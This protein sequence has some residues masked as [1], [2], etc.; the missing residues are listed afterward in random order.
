[1]T[2]EFTPYPWKVLE[3][4]GSDDVYGVYADAEN[5]FV[6]LTVSGPNKEAN[7]R[8]ISA[9]PELYEALENVLKAMETDED[10]EPQQSWLD[11]L[12]RSA[13]VARAALAKARGEQ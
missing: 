9:A 2:T 13:D 1:M 5:A 10:A 3:I 6:A 7:A 8:L 12:Y 11:N 4:A